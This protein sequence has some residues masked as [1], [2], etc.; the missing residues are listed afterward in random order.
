MGPLPE[1]A[2]FALL[3]TNVAL[4]VFDGVATYIGV[5]AGLAGQRV[6]VWEAAWVWV[7]E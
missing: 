2:M 3:C 4:Q 5:H 7:R 1:R 6:W